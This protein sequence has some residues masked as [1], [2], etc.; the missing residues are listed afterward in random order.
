MEIYVLKLVRLADGHVSQEFLVGKERAKI[1]SAKPRQLVHSNIDWSYYTMYGTWEEKTVEEIQRICNCI[2]KYS[3][4]RG[5][6]MQLEFNQSSVIFRRSPRELKE[7]F[8]DKR[9]IVLK[10]YWSKPDDKVRMYF[11][12]LR[13]KDEKPVGKFDYKYDKPN[14]RWYFDIERDGKLDLSPHSDFEK[15]LVQAYNATTER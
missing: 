5:W 4:E 12:C 11:N 7:K 13:D 1:R 14:N 6:K 9:I 2:S 10:S 3:D 8:G 15:V